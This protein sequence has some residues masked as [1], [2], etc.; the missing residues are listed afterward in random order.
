MFAKTARNFFNTE[1]V[2]VPHLEPWRSTGK[3]E[4]RGTKAVDGGAN[5]GFGLSG[6]TP[7]L[8]NPAGA[9]CRNWTQL[10]AED[11]GEAFIAQFIDRLEAAGVPDEAINDA[12][13][14]VYDAQD[15]ARG[16]AG[17]VLR[18]KPAPLAAAHFAAWPPFIPA[19]CIKASTTEAG[20]CS[21]CGWPL[22]PVVER[23][24]ESADATRGAYAQEME[25]QGR[26]S[27]AR[28]N[29]YHGLVTRRTLAFRP[30]CSC[31]A[32]ARAATIL[33]PFCGSGTTLL[34][35]DRLG[36]DA[37]GIDLSAEYC[38]LAEKRIRE[39]NSLF[40]EMETEAPAHPS[41]GQGALEF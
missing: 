22:V 29:G 28:S 20:V 39:D 11:P 1:G 25:R 16:A 41:S 27:Q 2:R 23:E 38:T 7:R 37:I 30:S 10:P 9:N 17:D 26:A 14:A 3:M 15:E 4:N 33:D 32:P 31:A 5:N 21:A 36:R 13:C 6:P 18:W 35:A 40:L 34:V 8:Y 19:W 12:L 24:G